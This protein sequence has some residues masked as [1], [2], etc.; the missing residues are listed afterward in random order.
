MAHAARGERER[1]RA[2]FPGERA[3]FTAHTVLGRTPSTTRRS[4]IAAAAVHVVAR[5]A[6]AV[7]EPSRARRASSRAAWHA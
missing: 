6:N 4:C 7:R 1:A 3:R 2:V 5:V